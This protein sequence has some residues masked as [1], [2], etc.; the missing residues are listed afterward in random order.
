MSPLRLQC[1]L[2]ELRERQN[3]RGIPQRASRIALRFAPSRTNGRLPLRTR[4]DQRRAR[5]QAIENGSR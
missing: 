4:H 1:V 5:F 2:G 3:S